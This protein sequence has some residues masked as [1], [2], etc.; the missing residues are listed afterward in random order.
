MAWHV[1][2]AGSMFRERPGQITPSVGNLQVTSRKRAYKLNSTDM[3]HAYLLRLA[4]DMHQTAGVAS[5]AP[6]QGNRHAGLSLWKCV[7]AAAAV[8]VARQ[9]RKQLTATFKI[10]SA[11]AAWQSMH[12]VI[13]II[14]QQAFQLI[15][16]RYLLGVSKP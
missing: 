12:A 7:L 4:A 5:A 9:V 15:V 8:A 6:V 11:S 16:A 14:S 3:L 13:T 2:Q 10:A 1:Q